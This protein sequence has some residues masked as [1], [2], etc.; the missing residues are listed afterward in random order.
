LDPRLEQVSIP[1]G[2]SFLWRKDDYPWR[3]AV[4]NCHPE[5]EIHLI[6]NAS[7]LAYVG[8]HICRFE[9]GHLAVVGSNLPHNWVTPNLDGAMIAERDIVVQ[10][11]PATLRAACAV[12]PEFRA[13]PP[14]LDR[15][16]RGLEILG[17]TAERA[18][19]CLEQMGRLAPGEA[20]TSLL[21]LL[22]SLAET[23]EYR[24]LASQQFVDSLRHGDDRQRGQIDRALQFIQDNFLDRPSLADVARLVGMSDSAFSRF[25]TR[26]TGN[27]F[28]DHLISLRIFTAQRFLTDSSHSVTDICYLAGFNNIA[29]FNRTF[30]RTTGMSPSAYRRAARNRSL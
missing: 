28:T 2:R 22:L 24:Y 15:A 12:F 25:F 1:P 26:C 14:F 20:T 23:E 30:L 18:R 9:S 11:D 3:R 27:S 5:V 8:D 10:F 16:A 21:Q 29:N 6:R 13:I 4:W 19:Q 17:K 7:G